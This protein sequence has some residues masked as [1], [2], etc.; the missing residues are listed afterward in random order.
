MPFGLTNAPAVFMRLM[1]E[2]FHDYLDQFVIVFI[3]DILIYSRREEDHKEHLRK[4]L[5][6]LRDRKLFA[7]FSKC[8]FWKR[9][10]GFLGHR[11]SEQGVSADPEKIA[12]V[13]GW[14]RPTT[15]SEIRSFLGLAGYYR[16]FVKGFS[17]IAKPLTKLTG[18]DVPLVWD[19]KTEEAFNKLKE[20]L[21]TAP[22]L[23]LPQ[24]GKIYDVYTDA[25]RVGLGC[26]IMQENKAIAYA[27]RQL[28]KHEENYPTHDLE[29]AAV[30]FALKIWRSY[31]YREKVQVFTDHKSL[32]YLFTQADLNLRQRR[33]ME[34][35]SD[36]DI[37]IQYHPG[38]ANVVA[39]ALSR[40][41]AVVKAE[42]DLENLSEEL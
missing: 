33:W 19:E 15:A 7:K 21:T 6:R 35:I 12:V 9:E 24:P 41:R 37:Q 11:V 5:E 34:F 4:V 32:K 20:A 31:L 36:Y 2:V 18:K 30:V 8:R 39:D 27:S 28:K 13:E 26:V 1:N 29:M 40:R 22:V 14:P 25:S 3:D 17:S 16:R 10:I 23:T 38:K 42:K